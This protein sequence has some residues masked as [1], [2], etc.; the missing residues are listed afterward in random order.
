MFGISLTLEN[1]LVF[2]KEFNNREEKRTVNKIIGSL[3]H[4]VYKTLVFTVAT[5]SFVGKKTYAGVDDAIR[6]TDELG[7]LLLSVIQKVGFWV[8]VLGC[9]VEILISVFK[10]GG[11]QK[12]I[13]GLVFKWLLIFACFYIVPS[14]FRLIITFFG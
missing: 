13:I 11:G 2:D 10:K 12:E 7:Y 9:I 8:C 6:K 4:K 14:L 1:K 5:I 3:D